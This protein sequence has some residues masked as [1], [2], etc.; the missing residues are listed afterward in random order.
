[1]PEPF[2]GISAAVNL[3]HKEWQRWFLSVKPQP[4]ESAQLP[5]EWETKCDSKLQK[6]IILR[7]FRPDRVNFAIRNYVEFYMKKEFIENRPTNLKETMLESKNNEPIIFVLS[8]GADP[9]DALKKLA[10]DNKVHF[11]AISMGKG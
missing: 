4:P 5:G 9:T 2:N 7:C 11:E 3:N 1:M 8:Q 6:M 10:D